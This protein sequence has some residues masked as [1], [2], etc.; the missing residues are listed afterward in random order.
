MF[1]AYDGYSTSFPLGYILD[2]DIIM[3][4]KMNDVVLPPERGR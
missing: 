2:N 4:Y 3:A 1:R